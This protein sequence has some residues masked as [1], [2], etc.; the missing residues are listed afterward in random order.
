MWSGDTEKGINVLRM[1][2]EKFKAH[3]TMKTFEILDKLHCSRLRSLH[4]KRLTT[5]KLV[6]FM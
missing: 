2:D 4:K 5:S 1:S 3:A 6:K